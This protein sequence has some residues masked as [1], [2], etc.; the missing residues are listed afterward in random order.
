MP[1][2]GTPR[3][4]I[5]NDNNSLHKR[6]L[7][8]VDKL[9]TAL[10]RTAQQGDA[11]VSYATNGTTLLLFVGRKDK[12]TVLTC[13]KPQLMIVTSSLLLS[14]PHMGSSDIFVSRLGST[15]HKIYIPAEGG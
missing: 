9:C 14:T 6:H 15:A 7:I 4:E 13:H 2:L 1:N 3:T 8:I 12:C 10:S 5:N 11:N